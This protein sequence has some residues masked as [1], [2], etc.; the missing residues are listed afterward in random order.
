MI[1]AQPGFVSAG[2]HRHRCLTHALVGDASATHHC[3]AAQMNGQVFVAV[4]YSRDERDAIAC[5]LSF[6]AAAR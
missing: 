2:D 3:D 4:A 1:A 5:E 6:A